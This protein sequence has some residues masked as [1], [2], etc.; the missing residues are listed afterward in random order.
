MGLDGPAY[1]D[2]FR[3]R[4]AGISDV[5]DSS[6]PAASLR[7]D[8][9]LRDVL[10]HATAP[11]VERWLH[12]CLPSRCAR[13]EPNIASWDIRQR[14]GGVERLAVT[15]TV[16]VAVTKTRTHRPKLQVSRLGAFLVT[17]RR[18]VSDHALRRDPPPGKTE[19]QP[20]PLSG[21]GRQRVGTTVTG[22][23]SG[24]SVPEDGPWVPGRIPQIGGIGARAASTRPGCWKHCCE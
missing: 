21:P 24:S 14:T 17:R 23:R 16:A 22:L 9:S 5:V 3:T 2:L 8:M 7:L 18:R 19:R 20:D 4:A 1:T 6:Q 11:V 12:N 13:A 10:A 15:V